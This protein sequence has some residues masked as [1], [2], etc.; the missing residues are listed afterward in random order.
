MP[1]NRMR[2]IY[3]LA[4]V[5]LIMIE[6]YIAVFIDSGFVR[7]YLGD[8][9]VVMV[10][11]FFIRIFIPTGCRLLPLYV[12]IFA[13]AVEITQLFHLVTLLGMQNNRLV[14][15]I[16]GG[17]FDFADILCYLIGCLIIFVASAII[18]DEK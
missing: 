7:N 9:L 4:F 1:K 5:L 13:V 6:V 12:F 11:Y 2:I 14:S 16:L 15:T 8:V 18:P 10:V 3:F 17:I